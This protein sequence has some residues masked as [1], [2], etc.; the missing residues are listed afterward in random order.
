MASLDCLYVAGS[1]LTEQG[2][3]Q[4][5]KSGRFRTLDTGKL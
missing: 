1:S 2:I 5:R 4:L 3:E